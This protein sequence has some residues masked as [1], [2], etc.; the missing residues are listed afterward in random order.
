M[1]KANESDILVIA[2]SIF[3]SL[4]ELGLQQ[5]WVTF[6]HGVRRWIGVHELYRV[7][8]PVKTKGNCSFT[9]CDTVSAF[10]NKDCLANLGH[11]PSGLSHLHQAKSIP[12]CT[13]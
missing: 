12:S 9:G 8:G 13:D 1:I 11:L 7:I 5:L 4:Q 10:R 6:G 3:P 2:L